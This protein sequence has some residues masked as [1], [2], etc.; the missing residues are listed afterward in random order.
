VIANRF[1]DTI[2]VG[3]GELKRTA[4]VLNLCAYRLVGT[5]L[6]V[7]VTRRILERL[8]QPM[9]KT[10]EEARKFRIQVRETMKNSPNGWGYINFGNCGDIRFVPTWDMVSQRYRREMRND[11]KD[12]PEERL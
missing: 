5:H 1:K 2:D 8:P 6:G 10:L 7:E 9:W 12:S 4:Q 3:Y 11:L